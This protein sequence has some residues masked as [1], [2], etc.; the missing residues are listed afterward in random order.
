MKMQKKQKKEDT[1]M[2]EA[3]KKTKKKEVIKRG[4]TRCISKRERETEERKEKNAD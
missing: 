3:D 1:K 4:N 2:S